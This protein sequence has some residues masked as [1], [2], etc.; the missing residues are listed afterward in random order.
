[1]EQQVRKTMA[2]TKFVLNERRLALLEAQERALDGVEVEEE[3][4]DMLEEPY[5]EEG[6]AAAAAG[7]DPA[8]A[9]LESGGSATEKAQL[10]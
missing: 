7:Q 1:M 4:A 9:M 6:A 2:R 10:R 8:S 5:E 3:G